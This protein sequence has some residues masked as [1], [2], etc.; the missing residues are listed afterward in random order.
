[1][2]S[3]VDWKDVLEWSLQDEDKSLQ[4]E[5][6]LQLQDEAWLQLQDE[7]W[8][9]D[10]DESLP[11]EHELQ[12]QDEEC[13]QDEDDVDEEEDAVSYQDEA[14]PESPELELPDAEDSFLSTEII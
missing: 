10:E 12:L 11:V 13:L 3:S 4:D 2:R 1:M 14:E 6:L 9:Q 8:L 5:A 7:E